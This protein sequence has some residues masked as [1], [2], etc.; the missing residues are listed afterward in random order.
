LINVGAKSRT[1]IHYRIQTQSIAQGTLTADCLRKC[2]LQKPSSNPPSI[3]Q[4]PA[5]IEYL[6]QHALN[7]AYITPQQGNETSKAYKRRIYNTPVTLLRE[8]SELP[9]MRITRL[10]DNTDWT[11]VWSNI[12]GTPVHEDIKMDCYRAVLDIVPTQDRLHR[13]HMA[14]TNLCRQCN[15]VDNLSHRLLECDEGQV[16]WDWTKGRIAIILRAT[17]RHTPDVWPLRPTFN[18][19][20]LQTTTSFTMDPCQFCSLPSAAATKSDLSRLL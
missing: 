3:Q 15:V 18:I 19:W 14:A 16:M 10:W 12:H 5:G 8:T 4:I 20:P 1:L 17:V 9:V 2:H 6:R 11:T 13:I 7:S